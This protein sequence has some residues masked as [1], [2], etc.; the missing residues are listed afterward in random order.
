MKACAG[1]TKPGVLGLWLGAVLYSGGCIFIS[2]GGDLDEPGPSSQPSGNPGVDGGAFDG[3]AAH[4]ATPVDGAL[5]EAGVDAGG[6]DGSWPDAT[7]DGGGYDAAP[8]DGALDAGSP[9]LVG[10]D[11]PTPLVEVVLDPASLVWGELPTGALRSFVSGHDAQARVCATLVWMGETPACGDFGGDGDMSFYV[12]VETATDGPCAAWDYGGN[13]E[14]IRAQG[15]VDFAIYHPHGQD[16][17]DMD[18]EVFDDVARYHIVADSRHATAPQPVSLGLR[19]TTD[20]PAEV[21]VQTLDD[22]GAPAWVQLWQD[23]LP[24]SMFDRCDVTFCDEACEG[25]CSALHPMIGSLTHGGYTGQIWQTWDGQ[26]RRLD[27]ERGCWVREPAAAGTYQARFCY[28]WQTTSGVGPYVVSP[29]CFEQSFVY[30]ADQVLGQA[31][32]AG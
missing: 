11:V 15:C 25:C 12:L 13:A 21:Y 8:D 24:L 5:A 2:I 16:L 20:V 4:D 18:V 1:W 32:D 29:T 22:A 28:G 7:W 31:D 3:H 19:Y 27:E 6:W 23:N 10:W 14:V 26:L 17:V 30:P 9:D